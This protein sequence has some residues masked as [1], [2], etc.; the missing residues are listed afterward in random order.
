MK[1]NPNQSLLIGIDL[2][3]KPDV[4]VTAVNYGGKTVPIP[5]GWQIVP[6]GALTA[7]GDQ[8]F[9]GETFRSLSRL[10]LASVPRVQKAEIIIRHPHRFYV[11]NLQGL[12]A[13][14]IRQ[15][16]AWFIV[17]P[18]IVGP[19]K[20]QQALDADLMKPVENRDWNPKNPGRK[21]RGRFL[22]HAAKGCTR[23]EYEAG[24]DFAVSCG[25]ESAVPPL[26][27]LDRG[28]VVGVAT[29]TDFVDEHDSDWFMGPGALVLTDVMPLPFT[30]CPGMLGFFNPVFPE[31]LTKEPTV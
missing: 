20:R 18:D 31:S 8:M 23:K 26:E 21:F 14:S 12:K 19:I 17:R 24:C 2:A 13:L 30:P 25:M 22:I 15:P 4:A 10:T 28:G 5:D 9:D 29:V 7:F 16:W 11:L 6:P 1:S 3:A 27:K